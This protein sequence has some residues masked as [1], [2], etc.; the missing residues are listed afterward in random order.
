MDGRLGEHHAG[1]LR[2]ERAEVKGRR[3][4]EEELQRLGWSESDLS[5]QPKSAAAKLAPAARLRR[6]TTMPLKWIAA[7]VNLGSSKSAN[8]KLHRWLKTNAPSPA[9]LRVPSV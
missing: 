8:A 6:E 9:A 2:R 3:I 5:G 1:D 7:R 4:I